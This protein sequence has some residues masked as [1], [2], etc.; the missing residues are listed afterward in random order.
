MLDFYLNYKC[1]INFLA[2]QKKLNFLLKKRTMQ[3]IRY[4]HNFN[5]LFK[6]NYIHTQLFFLY[7]LFFFKIAIKK[8]D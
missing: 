6:L 1:H 4:R 8:K 3:L 5:K 2:I 7:K